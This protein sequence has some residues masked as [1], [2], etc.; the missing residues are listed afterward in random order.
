MIDDDDDRHT[1]LI[2]DYLCLTAIIW[3]YERLYVSLGIITYP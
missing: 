1:S 2:H 3:G